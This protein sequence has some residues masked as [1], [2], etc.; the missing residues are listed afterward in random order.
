MRS[1]EW[2]VVRCD[3]SGITDPDVVTLDTLARLEL[4]ARRWGARIRLVNATPALVDLIACAGLGGVLEVVG[5][6]V[7]VDG[8]VEEREQRRVDEEVHGGDGAV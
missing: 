3:V 4:M 8:Q 7:E 5:S 1:P 2:I 6:G